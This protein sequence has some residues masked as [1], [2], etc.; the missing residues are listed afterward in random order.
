[1][2]EQVRA[3]IEQMHGSGWS[4]VLAVT[5]GGA[6][7]AAWLLGVPG[8]S[9]GVLEVQVPYHE[10]SLVQFLGRRPESFCSTATVRLLA[11]RAQERARGLVPGRRVAGVACTASLRSDRPK[12]GS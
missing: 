5:G 7:L 9:R 2:D 12:R 1:M 6:G 4:Y 10:E 8:A 3:R 11:R